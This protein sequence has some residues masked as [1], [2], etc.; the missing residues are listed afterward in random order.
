[1]SAMAT[2]IRALALVCLVAFLIPTALQGQQG[3]GPP[4]TP[5]VADEE[6]TEDLE[7][8]FEDAFEDTAVDAGVA[9]ERQT[10]PEPDRFWTLGG[11]ARQD[12]ANNYD[13]DHP[14]PDYHGLSR[15][16]GT[17]RLRLSLDLGG[18]WKARIAGQAF[19]DFAY[20]IKGRE[21]FGEEVLETHEQELEWR[22]VY[23]RGTLLQGLD[24]QVGR[25]IVVWGQA[26]SVRV[27]DMLNPMEN[28]DPGL[29]DLE[30]LRLP[31]TMTRIDLYSGPWRAMAVAVH[32][33]RF[34]NNPAPGSDFFPVPEMASSEELP[35][36][37][38]GNTEYGLAIQGAFSGWDV[39]LYWAQV[40]DDNPRGKEFAFPGGVQTLVLE[41]GR[42]TMTGAAAAL[43]VGNWIFK[44]EAAQI[45]GFEFMGVPDVAFRRTDVMVGAE[46]SGI[47][48][49]TLTIEVLGRTIEDFVALIEASPDAQAEE[50]LQT[51][52]S[53]RA[54]F[55]RET[56]SPAVVLNLLGGGG[57]QGSVG[58]YALT[59]KPIDAMAVTGGLLVFNGGN[60]ENARLEY[61]RHHDRIFAEIK[62]SF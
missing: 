5:G 6:D 49:T 9:A 3:S 56:L 40:F 16:R 54:N 2:A 62:Y 37:G 20:G 38:G 41:H 47:A 24:L 35:E 10:E 18:S 55:M 21:E 42:L 44:T 53:Y 58:R 26:D 52:L 25:Q 17:V 7:A 61:V 27:V 48:D 33:I 11:F 1:M 22:E 8:G 32:E 43:A 29:T 59:Y 57:E 23:V 51:A 60:G 15:L 19:H 13:T 45:S 30:E 39:G 36:S 14:E 31:V 34:D 12:A 28:R 50:V 4:T 46:Y